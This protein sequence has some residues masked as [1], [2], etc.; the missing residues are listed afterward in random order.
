M[1]PHSRGR[2]YRLTRAALTAPPPA[3]PRGAGP[4]VA[5]VVAALSAAPMPAA[6]QTAGP[7][8]VRAGRAEALRLDGVPDEPAWLGADS[9]TDF[10]QR[11]PGEGAPPTERTVVRILAGDEG[12]WVA[13]WCY[14][15]TPERIVRAQLRR[16]A[17]LD[18][19][20]WVGIVLDPHRDRRTG[21]AFQV[22]ANGAMGDAEVLSFENT[23]G[24]WD[25]VWDAR[26]RIGGD[27][28]T[29]EFF[30]PW[31]TLRYR[32]D[33]EGWGLNVGRFIRRNRE[34]ILWRGW[35]R[36]EGPY[37]LEEEGVLTG[38]G[39]LPARRLSEWRPY[40]AWSAR[41][42]QRDY[43]PDGS[44]E[45][46]G[47]REVT[48]KVGLDGKL[49][50]APTL[51]LDVTTNT[52]FAQ[53]DVDQQMVNLSRFPLFFPEKRPFFLEASGNFSFG[54][55][56]QAMAF[57]SRRIGLGADRMPVTID[58]GLRL[59]GRIGRERIGL[60][61][62]RTGG[63]EDAVDVVARVKH[64]ILSRGYVGGI[65]TGQGG[66]GVSGTRLTGGA[67]YELPF[68]VGGQN[69]VFSGYAMGTRDGGGAPTRTAGR[70]FADYPN[71][72]SDSY[73]GVA[74]VESGF[75]PALGFVQQ[76]GVWRH[77][78]SIEWNPRPRL[79]GV[80]QLSFTFIDW[81]VS[82]YVGGGLNFA[83]YEIS[84]LGI[85]FESG[86]EFTIE[87]SREI[88]VPEE[89]FDIWENGTRT[90]TVPAGRHAWNRAMVRLETSQGRPWGVELDASI[91]QFY[92]GTSTGIDVGVDLRLAP[93]VI[94]GWSTEA[95]W[96]RLPQGD[97]TAQEMQVR[98]DYAFT[99]RLG[100]MWWVQWDNE[101]ERMTLNARLH[102]IPK[103]GSDAYLV[104]DSGWPTGLDREGSLLRRIPWRR[105]SRGALV[106]KFVYYFRA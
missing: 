79:P 70:F 8:L 78:G 44:Y 17:D 51:T 95:E 46:G 100:T 101:S 69:L 27:G 82:H 57:Y 5:L 97:F 83:E 73:L 30:I 85:E 84:P 1:G 62:V 53:V 55:S 36:S 54:Q 106:G 11:E 23:N 26:A 10:R 81:T 61:A 47:D 56:E 25:G 93:H 13:F 105:P 35:R 103:P 104:W 40:L 7:P 6:A 14:D 28:W 65:L 21:F 96:V 16:D 15:R 4:I 94:A 50:V 43:A 59:S 67:D 66:P 72:W 19:D 88:D 74:W 64:D 58:A 71:D 45:L 18:G 80:R 3:A 63:S 34:E 77:T 68:I 99:P 20:D 9:I 89:P 24:D 39:R 31:Q 48:A 32:R 87:L 75:D 38:L 52:D 60:L 102:W 41:D 76:D 92:T 29:A 86:D 22:N 98:L 42:Y 2:L 33:G 12:L 91:G 90:V 49:A 37:F